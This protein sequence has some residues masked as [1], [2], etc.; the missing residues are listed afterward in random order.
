M[1]AE[2]T[3]FCYDAATVIDQGRRDAQEDAVVAAFGDNR[4]QGFAVLADG[5][6]GHAAGDVASALV[7]DR[8]HDWLSEGLDRPGRDIP[9]L[10]E[11]AVDA[12]N[13]AIA[14]TARAHPDTR[15]M[16]STVVVPV[17]ADGGL[18]WISVGDSPLFLLRDDRLYRLNRPHTLA[19]QLD[20]MVRRGAIAR[21]AAL[22]SAD[23]DALTSVL[24]G[25]P[26]PEIDIRD[27]PFQLMDGDIVVAA[28]DGL[29][30]IDETAIAT[31]L[32][33]H[34]KEPGRLIANRL[35]QAVQAVD[36][37]EQDNIALCVIKVSRQP[38]VAPA[39][40]P[41][42]R[43]R[44]RNTTLFMTVKGKKRR[45]AFGTTSACEGV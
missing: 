34:R 25:A 14:E 4:S 3:P 16:G 39:P 23:R 13:A 21:D 41:A 30:F 45:V 29:E 15:G 31:V 12:A 8:V 44:R 28:S 24:I 17:L 6:G 2:A 32:S 19:A 9:A 26:I 35:M 27:T 40:T 42:P 33:T 43:A 10:L 18:Y 11:Q 38:H 37:P 20:D 22:A 36:D 1:R 7:L 5:M